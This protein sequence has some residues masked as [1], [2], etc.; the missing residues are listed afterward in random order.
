MANEKV[1]LCDEVEKMLALMKNWY[2]KLSKWSSKQEKHLLLCCKGNSMWDLH[3]L[4]GSWISW[5]KEVL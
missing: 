2:N 4:Q 3:V 5:K 1:A